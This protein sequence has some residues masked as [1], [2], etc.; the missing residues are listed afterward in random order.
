M[1]LIQTWSTAEL[2]SCT[3]SR[4]HNYYIKKATRVTEIAVII[5]TYILQQLRLGIEFS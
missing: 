2:R 1:N 5:W 4:A 3:A